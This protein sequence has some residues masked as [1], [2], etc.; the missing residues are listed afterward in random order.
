MSDLLFNDCR[1]GDFLTRQEKALTDEINQLT[2][3]QV[4]NAS[5]EDLC[6][7]FAS[8]YCVDALEVNE[9]GIQ[10]DYGDAQ[11]DISQRIEY[12]VFDRSQPACVTGTRFVFYVPFTGEPQLFRCA[13]STRNL[14]PPRAAV[15][16]SDLVFIYDRTTHDAANIKSEFERDRDNLRQYLGWI[17]RDVGEFNSGIRQKASECISARRRKLLQDR[18]LVQDLGFPLRRRSDASTTYA[19]PAVKRRIVTRLPSVSKEPFEPEPALEMAEYEHILS[20]ISNM[21]MVMERGPRAFKKMG[22]EDLRQHFLVQ[23]NGQYEGQATG[24]TFNYEGRT[25]I[26]VRDKGRNIF[27]AECKFWRG[28]SRLNDALNQLLGYTSWRDT[29]TALLIFNRGGCMT[30]VLESIPE[31]VREHPN[32]KAER[33]YPSETGFRYVFGHRDDPNRELTLTILAFDVPG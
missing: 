1:L 24:E 4:L 30:T 12:A 25:D 3:E 11:V 20:V 5:G 27:V 22:E 26:L 17:A 33:A 13:P 18:G 7:H 23:L 28:P 29:K 19:S 21:V 15:R 9:S 16:G 6:N 2:E 10:V 14:N 32:H 8:K 31:V